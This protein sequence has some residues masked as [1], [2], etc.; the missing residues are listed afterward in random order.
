MNIDLISGDRVAPCIA[1]DAPFSASPVWVRY[2]TGPRR[3]SI[4]FEDGAAHDIST[5]VD[6]QIATRLKW[7][8]KIMLVRLQG[9]RP[10]E[11]Y[12]CRLRTFDEGGHERASA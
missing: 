11:G 12:E 3:M 7:A 4:I 8:R 1:H 2:E 5:P 9:G 10:V 6:E